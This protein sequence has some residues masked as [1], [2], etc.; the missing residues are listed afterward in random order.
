MSVLN[1]I[2]VTENKGRIFTPNDLEGTGLLVITGITESTMNDA[3]DLAV[4]AK[5]MDIV[6]A[7]VPVH[8]SL[9]MA[10]FLNIADSVII[11]RSETKDVTAQIVEAISPIIIGTEP[12]E[13][14]TFAIYDIRE[15]LM[16]A[17]NNVYSKS[18]S[19]VY[20]GAGSANNLSEAAKIALNKV[21]YVAKDSWDVKSI[22]VD[23]RTGRDISQDEISEAEEVIE[24]TLGYDTFSSITHDDTADETDNEERMAAIFVVMKYEG[25]ESYVDFIEH[26]SPENIAAVIELGLNKRAPLKLGTMEKFFE[27]AIRLGRAEI[28]K[29][30]MQHGFDPKALEREGSFPTDILEHALQRRDSAEEVIQLL[31]D[32]GITLPEDFVCRFFVW[33]TPALLKSLINHGWNV[34]SRNRDGETPL[35]NIVMG[36]NY[37]CVKIL[38]EAGADVNARANNSMTPLMHVAF[39]NM[40][41]C[42]DMPGIIRLLLEHGADINAVDDYGR[43]VLEMMLEHISSMRFSKTRFVKEVLPMILNAGADTSL[44][45]LHRRRHQEQEPELHNDEKYEAFRSNWRDILRG[46][47]SRSYHRFA[48]Q[49]FREAV[50][51]YDAETVK[52]LLEIFNPKLFNFDVDENF[53]LRLRI[54]DFPEADTEPSEEKSE[55]KRRLDA[56]SEI[57]KAISSRWVNVPLLSPKGRELTYIPEEPFMSRTTLEFH[58]GDFKELCMSYSPEALRRAISSGISPNTGRGAGLNPLRVIAE[59]YDQYYD[60]AGMFD[61]LLS[62]GCNAGCLSGTWV[63]ECL[64]KRGRLLMLR[65]IRKV[66]MMIQ[67]F[68]HGKE[69]EAA[70]LRLKKPR[71]KER[72]R[73]DGWVEMFG[74][75]SCLNMLSHM[76][77]LIEEHRDPLGRWFK[78]R[79]IMLL[80]CAC[81]GSVKDIED[82]LKHKADVNLPTWLGYTPLMYASVFNSAEAV[83]FLIDNGA[84]INARNRMN[85]NVL[86]IALTSNYSPLISLKD[87]LQD[88]EIIRVLAK[89]GADVNAAYDDGSTPLMLA[90]EHCKDSE[91]VAALIDAGADVNARRKDGKNALLIAGEAG[92]FENVRVLLAGGARLDYAE[93]DE[94]PRTKACSK[95]GHIMDRRAD[96]CTSCGYVFPVSDRY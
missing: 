46:R 8:S 47:R 55:I 53:H 22:L 61:V 67:V 56:G 62:E 5:K 83:K 50:N 28:I 69:D 7:G 4:T 25:Y 88:P 70:G 96:Y 93:A 60:A 13:L 92:K 87:S 85:Q 48:G 21:G 33:I 20:F 39:G 41:K 91:F 23:F 14:D 15:L 11:S 95:C 1:I 82:A 30:L 2:N 37:D 52:E 35:M 44:L 54:N 77:D 64:R 75:L 40:S 63:G 6:T 65:D 89:A 68:V 27:A 71:T 12:G 9:N 36:K 38:I 16:S 76:W 84:D 45:P 49:L 86:T 24:E 58:D 42:D 3:L 19:T 80:V 34:N 74:D 90:A 94:S 31:L 18:G 17:W 29:P 43:S 26:E 51:N 72:G 81:W 66:K 73:Y 78:F 57:L 32:A 59:E 79:Q 10:V